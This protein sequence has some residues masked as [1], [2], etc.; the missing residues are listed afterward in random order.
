[1]ESRDRKQDEREID[2][3]TARDTGD[4][5]RDTAQDTEKERGWGRGSEKA[6]VTEIQKTSKDTEDKQRHR[7]GVV[8]RREGGK[9]KSASRSCRDAQIDTRIQRKE[10]HKR[11]A[12]DNQKRGRDHTDTQMRHGRNGDIDMKRQSRHGEERG[13]KRGRKGGEVKREHRDCEIGRQR[14]TQTQLSHKTQRKR[15]VGAEDQKKR[16]LQRCGR[17]IKTQHTI[18]RQRGGGVAERGREGGKQ[19]T[20]QEDHAEMRR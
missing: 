5:H 7:E 6:R 3:E 2:Q 16:E 9:Q 18:K 4:K 10:R 17:Q 1:M 20:Q 8:W 13:R 14:R 11:I 15:G 12:R 19:K